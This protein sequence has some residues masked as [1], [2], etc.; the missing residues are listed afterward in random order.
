M[1]SDTT[2]VQSIKQIIFFFEIA[3]FADISSVRK[4]WIFVFFQEFL[5]H[6]GGKT[7]QQMPFGGSANGLRATDMYAYKLAWC[8]CAPRWD[9]TTKFYPSLTARYC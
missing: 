4:V 1:L 3:A 9:M 7:T 5:S 8:D 6:A 2:C